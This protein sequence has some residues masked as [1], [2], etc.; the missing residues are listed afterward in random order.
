MSFR[1][2]VSMQTRE[3]RP[4]SRISDTRKASGSSRSE[5]HG[6]IG[7]LTRCETVVTEGGRTHTAG[8][9]GGAESERAAAAVSA[10]ESICSACGG[11]G[12]ADAAWADN[13]ISPAAGGFATG[14][15]RTAA[16][17]WSRR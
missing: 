17:A 9:G 14:L 11:G 15:G 1:L 12:V 7:K 8:H 16:A 10:I 4:R 5:M 6:M 13:A 3:P 2:R